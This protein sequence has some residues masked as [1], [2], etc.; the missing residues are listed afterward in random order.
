MASSAAVDDA[1]APLDDSHG[2]GVRPPQLSGGTA[3]QGHLNDLA[4][5]NLALFRRCAALGGLVRFRIYWYQC[6]VLTDPELAGAMLVTHAA[7]FK[8]TRALQVARPTFGNGLV[9][10]EGDAWRR[11][12]RLM[13]AFF[14]PKA[15]SLYAELIID[16]IGRK[17]QSWG[18]NGSEVD[19]HEDMV[20]VSL[21]LICRALF[22]LDATRLQP[23]VRDAAHAVQ[24]W[25]SDCQA[26]CLPYPHYFPIPSNYR[27][28]K[29]THA[30]NRVVYDLIRDVRASGGAEHGLLGAMLN[31]RDEDGSVISDQEVRDQVVTLF[32]AGH[33][34]T[35]SSL[36]LALYE[37]SFRPDLQERIAQESLGREPSECL[38]H[39]LKETL[40]L[41]PA[42]H[43]VGRTALEDVR[44]G[45]FLVKRGEEVIL[46]LHVLQRDPRFFSRPEEFVPERWAS[47]PGPS[48]CQRYA[49]LPF[50][51]GPRVCIGQAVAMAELRGIVTAI[52]TRFRLTPLGER[53]P[54]LDTRLTLSPAP[55]VTRVAVSRVLR[56]APPF[57][58][59]AS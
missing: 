54:R 44:L 9:T 19:L 2:V 40:R 42:V 14:T 29:R 15:A 37:L 33:D 26:L 21:E 17:L 6:H 22:G 55:G 32:L 12:Q 16:C 10:S 28:R 46:P 49:H 39:V 4:S 30:L 57:A 25:H 35:A 8:K 47:P 45:K 13:R 3:L 36:A 41:Y 56:G 51:T 38:E 59:S 27:Y 53:A 20:D 24:Q 23:L 31:A 52:L 43:L 1:D 48:A 34:T 18:G 5:D 11:Q 50:S 58:V 7:S